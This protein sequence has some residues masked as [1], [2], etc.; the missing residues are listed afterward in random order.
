M[1]PPSNTFEN[2]VAVPLTFHRYQQSNQDMSLYTTNE[3]VES[4]IHKSS[5]LRNRKRR[6]LTPTKKKCV[7]IWRPYLDENNNTDSTITNAHIINSPPKLKRYYN[8]SPPSFIFRPVDIPILECT[9]VTEKHDDFDR[10]T[11]EL[12]KMRLSPDCWSRYSF[13]PSSSSVGS[14]DDVTVSPKLKHN[15]NGSLK[16]NEPYHGCA[17]NPRLKRSKFNEEQLITLNDMFYKKTYLSLQERHDLAAKL[18]LSEEQVKNWFQN[19]RMKTKRDYIHAVDKGLVIPLE[20]PGLPKFSRMPSNYFI[21]MPV[22]PV[23]GPIP[24]YQC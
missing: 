17:S 8:Q 16:R 2:C 20:N 21:S 15:R 23:K 19:K 24:K 7:P 4:I 5:T 13:S 3:E 14:I 6:K 11:P 9:S 18:Q 10:R 1:R 12:V 22:S